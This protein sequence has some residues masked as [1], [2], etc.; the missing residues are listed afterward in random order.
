M[1]RVK[2]ADLNQ[3][4]GVVHRLRAAGVEPTP[5]GGNELLVPDDIDPAVLIGVAAPD[6]ATHNS[7]YMPAPHPPQQAAKAVR[8]NTRNK[9]DGK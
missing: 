9:S 7:L 8:R 5:A 6:E 2:V 3:M 1:I 4:I